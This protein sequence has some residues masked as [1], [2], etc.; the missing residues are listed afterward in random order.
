MLCLIADGMGGHAAGDIAA[1]LALKAFKEA[2]TG[3]GSVASDEFLQ[4]IDVANRAV[5]R[6]VKANPDRVG[7]GCTLLAAEISA[8]RINWI[9]VG[10]QSCII[11][12]DCASRA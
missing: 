6:H 3:N 11:L 1:S 2:V 10:T 9:S 4:G 8:D 12:M 5:A 7:M